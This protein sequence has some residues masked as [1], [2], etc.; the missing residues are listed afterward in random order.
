MKSLFYRFI[1]D[2][3]GATAIEY[4]IIAALIVTALISGATVLG[5]ALNNSMSN[6]ANRVK[7]S[8]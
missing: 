6:T 3:S 4:G 7:D 1:E 8:M 5:E 2:R